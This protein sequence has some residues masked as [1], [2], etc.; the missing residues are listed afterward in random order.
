M[1]KFPDVYD[2]ARWLELLCNRNK[3]IQGFALC[4]EIFAF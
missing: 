4:R 2:C 1:P 3:V